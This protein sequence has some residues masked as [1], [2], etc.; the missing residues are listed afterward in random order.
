MAARVTHDLANPTDHDAQIG[1]SF[2]TKLLI[3]GLRA[4]RARQTMIE[5]DCRNALSPA[6]PIRVAAG[7]RLDR[8]KYHRVWPSDVEN[9]VV[10]E[11]PR[12][13]ACY[14]ADVQRAESA[15][16]LGSSLDESRWTGSSMRS[17]SNGSSRSK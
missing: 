7:E 4:E 1:P 2:A 11:R 5:V 8:Q 3:P 15:R 13:I 9:V 17:L 14:V 16:R 10:V 12:Q 6:K